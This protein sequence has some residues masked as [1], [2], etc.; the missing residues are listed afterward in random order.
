MRRIYLDRTRP[1]THMH[2]KI[3][4]K[5]RRKAR[6]AGGTRAPSRGLDGV[7]VLMWEAELF[8]T[9]RKGNKDF[10]SAW[11]TGETETSEIL[12]LT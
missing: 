11:L 5:D 8:K 3:P 7:A 9:N 10:S 2:T 1:G 4:P 6:P 12:K